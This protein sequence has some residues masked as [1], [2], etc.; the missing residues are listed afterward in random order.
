LV[1]YVRF[2]FLSCAI[3]FVVFS[4]GCNVWRKPLPVV[5]GELVVPGLLAEVEVL[6]DAWGVPHIYASNAHDLSF[7]QG[8]VHAQDRW[9]QMDFFRRAGYGELT[10]LLGR[11]PAV[12]EQ[13]VFFRTLGFRGVVEAEFDGLSAETQAFLQAFADGVNAYI[14]PRSPRELAGEY[15]YLPLLGVEVTVPPWQPEDSL[16]WGKVMAF[17]L[18]NS[19]GDE[20]LLADFLDAVGPDMV[21]DYVP[22]YP[23]DL[24]PTIIREE[25]LP[26]AK[27]IVRDGGPGAW[28]GSWRKANGSPI[29]DRVLR[30]DTGGSNNWVVGGTRSLSGAPLLANDPH[31]PIQIPALFLE[32]GLHCTSETEPL[33]AVGFAFAATPGIVIGHNAHIA[34][35]VTNG[36]GVDTMDTYLLRVNPADPLQYEWNGGFRDMTVREETITFGGTGDPLTFQVRATHHGPV[37]TDNEVPEGELAVT[38]FNS[39]DPAALRWPGFEPGT[40]VET[41]FALMRAENWDEFRAALAN[42]DLAS[43]HFVYADV[44]GNIGYQLPGRLPIRSLA[45]TGDLPAPGWSDEYEWQGFIPFDSLPRLLNPDRDFIATAN[46]QPVPPGFADQLAADLGAGF[47]YKITGFT[48]FGY[49]AQRIEELLQVKVLHDVASFQNIQRD[50]IL[51]SALEIALVLEDLDMGPSVI[52]DARDNLIAWD[53]NHDADSSEAALWSYFWIRL[54]DN[55]F[56][57]EIE[58]IEPANGGTVEMWAVTRLLDDPTNP[59]WD[60]TTTPNIAE[61]RDQVLV[62]SFV[63]G[64]LAA[65]DALGPDRDAWRWGDVHTASFVSSPLGL[66]GLGFLERQVNRGPVPAAGGSATVNASFWDAANE[67]FEVLGIPVMRM[68]VDLG[69]LTRSVVVN[70]TGQ[71]GHPRSAHYDDQIVPWQETEGHP[72]LWTREQVDAATESVLILRPAE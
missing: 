48:A 8:Y 33:D 38:G 15:A 44:A 42:W 13:D 53:G 32:V 3:C 6:R 67:N 18:S 10:D 4:S 40:L 27:S 28:F 9:W 46:H 69:D 62:N 25:E 11:V 19:A 34:W 12:L 31:Q 41:P 68:V 50:T 47:T 65:L 43:Q 36:S 51:I 63:E 60:D 39:E 2:V 26:G 45:H 35:G 71:S 22:P 66:S 64:Y 17:Q 70:S 7:A 24:R 54:M 52:N 20:R 1:R 59:W 21:G 56:N 72:M 30:R 61:T 58:E 23:Y 14:G 16:V 5:D 49:R 29:L 55:L 57:D 37:I